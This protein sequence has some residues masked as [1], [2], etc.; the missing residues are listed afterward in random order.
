MLIYITEYGGIN[1][2]AID[3][4]IQNGHIVLSEEPSTEK[5]KEVDVLFIRTYTTINSEYLEAYPNVKYILRAGVG[6]DNIDLE[7]CKKRNIQVINAP[8][9]N[10]NAVAE[11]VIG[12][13]IQLSRKISIQ[14]AL[15]KKGEWREKKYI[16]SELTG[17]T[18]GLVGC[19][20]IGKLISYKLQ[21]FGVA[22]ILG[23]DP[24]LDEKLSFS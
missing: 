4:L 16:G 22:H 9:S 6:L 17:K 1:K 3:L 15:L 11:F 14:S 21:V 12:T 10:A 23:Y 13:I 20:A 5:K 19:G 24:Y 7:E 18:I 2:K 8:G